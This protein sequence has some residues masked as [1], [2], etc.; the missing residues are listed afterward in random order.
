MVD[1]TVEEAAAATRAVHRTA[2]ADHFHLDFVPSLL[3]FGQALFFL[4]L[5]RLPLP[6]LQLFELSGVR[7]CRDANPIR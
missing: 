1:L 2:A 5:L 7:W 3:N 4:F 6:P